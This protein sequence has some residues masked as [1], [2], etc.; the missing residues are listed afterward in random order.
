MIKQLFIELLPLSDWSTEFHQLAIMLVIDG[1]VKN[2]SHFMLKLENRGYDEATL[3]RQGYD[4]DYIIE[5]PQYCH[6]VL[7]ELIRILDTYVN[8]F[9]IKDRLIV[10]AWDSKYYEYLKMFFI[11]NRVDD[12]FNYFSKGFVEIRSIIIDRLQSVA[13]NYDPFNLIELSTNLLHSKT[14]NDA[15]SRLVNIYKLYNSEFKL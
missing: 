3:N 15:M 4:I 12:F 14:N 5:N 7:A 2:A 10:Y 1:E 9:S 8:K 13:M 11:N 6:E